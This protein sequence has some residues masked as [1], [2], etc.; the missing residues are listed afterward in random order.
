M[1]Q[2]TMATARIETR[3]IP[4][5]AAVERRGEVNVVEEVSEGDG[6]R[7]GSGDDVVVAALDVV[8]SVGDMSLDVDRGEARVLV[9][10]GEGVE[11]EAITGVAVEV[12][13]IDW[14]VDTILASMELIVE[15]VICADVTTATLVNCPIRA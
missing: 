15:D 12:S 11:V 9:E 14:V 6:T 4:T 2:A 1:M 13:P 8:D 10:V 7:I 3:V 5:M